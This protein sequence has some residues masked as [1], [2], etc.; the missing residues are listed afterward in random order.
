MGHKCDYKTRLQFDDNNQIRFIVNATYKN[1]SLDVIQILEDG[2]ILSRNI[3]YY[4]AAGYVVIF[5]NENLPYY[6]GSQNIGLEKWNNNGINIY[7]PVD[8]WK[9]T[10]ELIG[11]RRDDLKYLMRKIHTQLSV[12]DLIKLI[13]IYKSNE[14][15]EPLVELGLYELALNKSLWRMKEVNQNKILKYC[16]CH[17]S[18][19]LEIKKVNGW[20]NLTKI[21]R[22]MRDYPE[23]TNF[24]NAYNANSYNIPLKSVKYC[25]KKNIELSDYCNYLYS[26]N[27]VGHDTQSEYWLYP[28]DFQKQFDKINDELKAVEKAEEIARSD[29]FSLG[30]SIYKKLSLKTECV[31]NGYKL[32]IPFE[33]NDVVN[34]A[35]KLNQCLVRNNYVEKMI[36][37]TSILIFIKN[38]LDNAPVATAEI[39]WN[40]SLIQLYGYEYQG[41]DDPTHEKSKVSAELQEIIMKYIKKIKLKKPTQKKFVD[42][43]SVFYKGV[44]EKLESIGGSDKKIIYEK[45]KIYDTKVPNDQFN[46]SCK[47]SNKAIHFCKDIYK[48]RNYVPNCSKIIILK[49]IG[50]VCNIGDEYFSNKI[51]ILDIVGS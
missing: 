28:N 21:R 3:Y 49:V 11:Q 30:L 22:L 6:Y 8:S 17:L 5:P 12:Y 44:S 26:I 48:I 24:M 32:Y 10:I 14:K 42:D 25:S 33:Y 20:L 27:R 40:K 2:S 4:S 34:Q 31:M 50:K 35:E 51:K 38:E 39:D 36:N 45:G 16:K 18:E 43:G 1:Q 46:E 15:I 7:A 37:K 41:C 13:N 47:S 9:E 29:M 23:N 19:L